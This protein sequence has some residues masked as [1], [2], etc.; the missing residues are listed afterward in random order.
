MKIGFEAENLCWICC[1]FLC[2]SCGCPYNDLVICKDS[3]DCLEPVVVTFFT[4][5]IF[6]IIPNRGSLEFFGGSYL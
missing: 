1:H 6:I 5:Q 4:A 2:G 3:S